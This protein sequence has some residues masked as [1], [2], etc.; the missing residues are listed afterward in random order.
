MTKNEFYKIMEI[1]DNISAEEH[2]YS[3]RHCELNKD[4]KDE[5]RRRHRDEECF[6]N[7][8]SRVRREMLEFTITD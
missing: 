5:V 6:N 2:E 4:N 8:L 1:I 7:A 3:E